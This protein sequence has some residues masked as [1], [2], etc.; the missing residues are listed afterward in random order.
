MYIFSSLTRP[1][2]LTL[3]PSNSMTIVRKNTGENLITNGPRKTAYMLRKLQLNFKNIAVDNES[4]H[5]QQIHMNYTQIRICFT[6]LHNY[7][8]HSYT[9]IPSA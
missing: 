1:P 9:W 2:P 3:L 8:F 5:F 4:I 7:I 6:D